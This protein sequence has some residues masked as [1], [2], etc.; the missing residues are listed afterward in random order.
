MP[1]KPPMSLPKQKYW[2]AWDL[3]V[4][5]INAHNSATDAHKI[6]FDKIKW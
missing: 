2:E 6:F 3:Y 1:N 4:N 5:M